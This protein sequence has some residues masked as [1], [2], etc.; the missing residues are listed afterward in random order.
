[1]RKTWWLFFGLSVLCLGTGNVYGTPFVIDDDPLGPNTYWGG[2]VGP[3]YTSQDVLAA[4]FYDFKKM[5]IS[6]T[7][8][9]MTVA[10]FGDFS[11]PANRGGDLY[12]SSKG[13]KVSGTGPHFET[14]TFTKDEGWDYVISTTPPLGVFEL[15]FGNISSPIIT[16]STRTNQ[17]WWG[18]YKKKV[19][20]VT[21]E[22]TDDKITLI[23]DTAKLNLGATFG[24]HFTQSCGNDVIE[25]EVPRV[26]EP[27]TMLLLGC[28][29]VGLG[30][31][32]MRKRA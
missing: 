4:S 31:I 28:G 24:L 22:T 25:G 27:A 16:T 2:T 10:I 15:A 30:M 21:I 7:G 1:M 8:T 19:D 29:L 17:A 26:P 5:E 12:L 32:K 3:A 11:H 14:D 6:F 20:D 23:F 18:G 9:V 13:W